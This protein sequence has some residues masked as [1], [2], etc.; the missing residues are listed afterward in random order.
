MAQA[1]GSAT[2]EDETLSP[3]RCTEPPRTERRFQV[4]YLVDLVEF[5]LGTGHTGAIAGQIQELSTSVPA[6]EP[7]GGW[8]I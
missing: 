3:G 2:G 8:P 7:P 5:A 1:S 6:Q 4:G